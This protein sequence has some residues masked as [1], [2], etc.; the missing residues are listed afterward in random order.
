MI[1]H[2]YKCIFIHIQRTGG[3]SIERAISGQDQAK[4][5]LQTK[6]ILAKTAKE[7][8]KDYWNDYFKFSFVR[9]PWDRMLS[10]ASMN[11]VNTGI[12]KGKVNLG[13][14]Q[15]YIKEA[16]YEVPGFS[17]S[18]SRLH[19]YGDFVENSIYCNILNEELD[20]IGRFENLHEDFEKVCKEIGYKEKLPEDHKNVK[21]CYKRYYDENSKQLVSDIYKED[22]KR[23]NYS[24]D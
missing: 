19:T 12:V 11:W 7:I 5:F 15:N 22:L 2:E 24:F 13:G 17:E 21:G 14:Y 16:K 18:I 9:N 10:I 3:T 8:Y 1:S 6:H 20:F 23:F 4:K